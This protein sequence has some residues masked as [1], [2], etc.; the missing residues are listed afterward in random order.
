MAEDKQV[1]V[2]VG[3]FT[4]DDSKGIYVFGMDPKTGALTLLDTNDDVASPAYL[5][6]HPTKRFLY[7][8]NEVNDFGGKESGGLSAF[9][10]NPSTGALS[11]INQQ[12]S[13]A[14]DLAT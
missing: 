4:R 12:P 9:T 13:V 6:I 1:L 8:V 2:F 3:T 11:L 14:L 7:A 5:A 10:L